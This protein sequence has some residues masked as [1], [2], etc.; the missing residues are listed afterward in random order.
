[1]KKNRV[2]ITGLGFISPVG[3]GEEQFWESLLNGN[4][5]V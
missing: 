4:I 2:V 3:I 5:Q 1:M